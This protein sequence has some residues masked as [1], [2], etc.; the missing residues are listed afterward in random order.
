MTTP[1]K[2]DAL[3]RVGESDL[4]HLDEGSKKSAV[5]RAVALVRKNAFKLLMTNSAVTMAYVGV[6][7]YLQINLQE[8]PHQI[9]LRF[10][11]MNGAALLSVMGIDL[12]LSSRKT[13]KDLKIRHAE[14][15]KKYAEMIRKQQ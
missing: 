12:A 3:A 7:E 8:V 10:L 6:A 11:T 14:S 5:R 2:P 9:I 13:L 1:H 4:D 15:E